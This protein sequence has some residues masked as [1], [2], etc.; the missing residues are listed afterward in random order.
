MQH[1]AGLLTNFYQTLGNFGVGGEKFLHF[2]QMEIRV[3]AFD[4]H[5][6]LSPPMIFNAY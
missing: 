3:D 1:R 6:F 5:V 4:A 2:N